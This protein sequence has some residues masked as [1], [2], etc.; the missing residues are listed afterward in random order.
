MCMGVRDGVSTNVKII[1]MKNTGATVS[2]HTKRTRTCRCPIVSRDIPTSRTHRVCWDRTGGILPV[3]FQ[4]DS[5]KRV[6][7]LPPVL[8]GRVVPLWPTNE[9][10]T[11]T[12]TTTSATPWPKEEESMRRRQQQGQARRIR[13]GQLLSS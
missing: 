8:F 3:T 4:D 2:L 12:T 10:M 13:H 7:I 5:P 1:H 9:M 6:R 11:T